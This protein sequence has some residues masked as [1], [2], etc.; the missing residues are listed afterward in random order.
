MGLQGSSQGRSTSHHTVSTWWVCRPDS[1]G[2]ANPGL[3]FCATPPPHA[4][5][6]KQAPQFLDLYAYHHPRLEHTHPLPPCCYWT[7]VTSF[8]DTPHAPSRLHCPPRSPIWTI[9]PL[10]SFPGWKGWVSECRG[11]MGEH[12][13]PDLEYSWVPTHG[14]GPMSQVR[15]GRAGLLNEELQAIPVKPLTYHIHF[16]YLAFSLLQGTQRPPQK[17]KQRCPSMKLEPDIP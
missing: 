9:S 1:Y 7:S 17:V 2:L 5:P 10:P 16:G 15:G 12:N 11:R 4:I 14:C 6:K 3:S 13:Q 8:S